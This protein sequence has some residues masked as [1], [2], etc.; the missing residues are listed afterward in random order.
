MGKNFKGLVRNINNSR[1]TPNQIMYRTID[2]YKGHGDRILQ[3]NTNGKWSNITL[4][5]ILKI[6]D[7]IFKNEDIVYP[8]SE[9]MKG[10]LYL[11]EAIQELVAGV[12]VEQI[13]EK[14]GDKH[15]G[16]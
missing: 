16:I 4:P 6:L 15:G 3:V 2:G 13:L 7:F 14:Y 9:G 8:Q 1:V 12:T 5:D 11:F 10:R